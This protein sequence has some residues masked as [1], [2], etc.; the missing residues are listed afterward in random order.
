MAKATLQQLIQQADQAI[1]NQQ[2]Q[3]AERALRKVLKQQPT[4]LATLRQ[5]A[6]ALGRQ[7]QHAK[8]TDVCRKAL[9]LEADD[10]AMHMQLAESQ[11]ELG[12]FNDAIA[13]AGAAI[14]LAPTDAMLRRRRA[15]IRLKLGDPHGSCDDLQAAHEHHPDDVHTLAALVDGYIARGVVPMDDA[16][17]RL[18]VARQPYEAKNHARLGTTL[19]LNGLMDEALAAYDAAL[20]IDRFNSNARAGKAEILVSSRQ[21]EDAAELLRPLINSPSCSILPLQ[22]WMR[23][24]NA[25][26]RHEDAITAAERWLTIERRSPAHITSICH[27]LAQAYDKLDRR[28]EAFDAWTRANAI[29]SRRWDADEHTRTTD[30]LMST[31]SAEAFS[32]LPRSGHD[33]RLPVF[34]LGMFRSGTSLTAQILA[35]HPQLHGAGELP[36]MLEIAGALP[37]TI[38]TETHYPECVR[39]VTREQ[40]DDLAGQYLDALTRGAGPA[41]RCTDKLPMNY[42]NIGLI[43][44][45]LPTARIIHC[46]RDP[47]DTCF[48]CWG[49]PFSS[50]T[51]FTANQEALGHAYLDYLRIMEHWKDVAPLPIHTIVYEELV[52]NPEPVIR[53][54]LDFLELDW[55]DDCLAFHESRRVAQTLSMDQ[56]SRPLS[57]SSIHR[58]RRY[59][60]QLAPLRAVLGNLVPDSPDA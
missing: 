4:N 45:L 47:L 46:T 52:S 11:Y 35:S 57:Q 29:D 10:P 6:L 28:D 59:W 44:M 20:G 1:Q 12:A 40:L 38:G 33:T 34:I 8:A 49:N 17:A 55:H 13:S 22:S 41:I 16:P 25:L 24:C 51:A 58:S 14:E 50:R 27:R 23:A 60:D 3:K 36:D 32:T 19:R 2:W 18:L 26:E 21:S 43:T 15:N 54:M 37:D 56:V 7:Q 5:L 9:Q 39:D 53:G 48:S 30:R 42:L 31:F